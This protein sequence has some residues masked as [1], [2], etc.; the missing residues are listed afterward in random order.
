LNGDKN[1]MA[2]V[3]EDDRTITIQ[4]KGDG[5]SGYI[6]K[7]R[8]TMDK[9]FESYKSKRPELQY[10]VIPVGERIT[11]N[12]AQLHEDG[13]ILLPYETIKSHLETGRE[14]FD[15][16][17]RTLIDLLR[18]AAA[19]NLHVHIGDKYGDVY[20][21]VD[22][23]ETTFN[24]HDCNINLQGNLNE[25]IRSLDPEKDSAVVKELTDVVS[26]LEKAE[27]LN[28]PEEAKKKGFL[29]KLNRFVQDMGDENSQTHKVIK[30]VKNGIN[31][32]QEIVK[33]YTAISS[34]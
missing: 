31:I 34:G 25:L 9:I 19:F 32:I 2:V 3:I 5:K 18:T 17:S 21:T 10:R 22:K 15:P 20:G 27:S 33:A 11:P 1:T 26:D 23:R 8:E 24:F 28:S 14:Y 7:L 13:G 6:S 29:G 4:V 30:G 16:L 12:T